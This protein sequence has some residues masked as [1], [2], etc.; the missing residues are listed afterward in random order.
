MTGL[1]VETIISSIDIVMD[2]RRYMVDMQ[3][4]EEYLVTNTSQRV[5]NIIVGTV[6]LSD[7]WRGIKQ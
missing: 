1:D 4:P 7:K 5:L 2:K 3:M 6:K